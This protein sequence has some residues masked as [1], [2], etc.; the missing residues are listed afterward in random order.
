MSKQTSE[1][2][3]VRKQSEQ[4]GASKRVSGAGERANGRAS[5]PVCILAYSGPQVSADEGGELIVWN[6]TKEHSIVHKKR[7][8]DVGSVTSMVIHR[9]TLV[10]G[11]PTKDE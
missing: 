2:S 7:V 10:T 6:L 4:G 8:Q 3:G 11:E 5:G 1:R 9:D